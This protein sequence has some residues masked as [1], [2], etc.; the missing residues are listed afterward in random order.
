MKPRAAIRNISHFALISLGLVFAGIDASASEIP[1][2]G[3]G[4]HFAQKK[5]NQ[6][7]F[8]DWIQQ[9]HFNSFRDEIYWIDIEPSPQ[10]LRPST[11]ALGT[12]QAITAAK[13]RGVEPLVVL[14]YGNPLY[15]GGS[16]PY[17]DVGREGFERYSE[18]IA[19]ATKGRVNYFEI[20]NEWNIGLGR[21]PFVRQGAA[22]DYVKLAKSASTAIRRI[23][24]SAV[25]MGGAITDD[26]PDWAWLK[27]AIHLGLLEHVDAVS[28]H[29]YNHSMP[30][31]KGGA[32]EMLS[33]TRRAHDILKAEW[34]KR[35]IPIYI[36]EIGWPNNSGKFGVSLADAAVQATEFL[37]EVKLLD[38]V[39]GVWFYEF[40]NGGNDPS[41]REDNFGFIDKEGTQKPIACAM[42]ALTEKLKGAQLIKSITREKSRIVAYQLQS[43]EQLLAAWTPWVNP[44]QDSQTIEISGKD[45][46]IRALDLGCFKQANTAKVTRT[47]NLLKIEQGYN[48]SIYILPK[49]SQLNLTP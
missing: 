16:Q 11:R 3:V 32:K 19:N 45:I 2:I 25:I 34:P 44:S 37:L 23:N 21:R 33:R 40:Q 46:D 29:L 26:T 17:T 27:D 9:T 41:A 15:D 48:P 49:K 47:A 35:D 6:K 8:L 14:D 39:K 20:W 30:L 12:L 31:Y 5:T 22:E 43:G 13:E 42:T 36:T 10:Q 18:W 1:L 28:I 7:I 4:T 24:P 38:Y